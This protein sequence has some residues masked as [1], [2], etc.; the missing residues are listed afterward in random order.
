MSL[1]AMIH[2][3]SRPTEFYQR[4]SDHVQ[5][6]DI[7]V[8]SGGVSYCEHCGN[9]LSPVA[10]KCPNCGQPGP[11]VGYA[12]SFEPS[13]LDNVELADYWRR[14]GASLIDGVIASAFIVGITLPFA[15]TATK[16]DLGDGYGPVVA[17]LLLSTLG[18]GLYRTLMEGSR[19]GQ[20]LGKMVLKIAVRDERTV[21]PIG[22]GRAL[23]RW[24]VG[25][26]AWLLF[27]LP[28]V[29]DLLFPLWDQK[30][31]TLHDKAARSVVVSLRAQ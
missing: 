24:L 2:I 31:Q 23:I 12:R 8:T 20:T 5:D 28:G 26:G 27:Y 18:I 19:R 11:Q 16:G 15:L 25:A 14:V 3:L 10:A 1:V 30:N 29:I 9:E 17:I 7:H 13:A 21:A 6:A 22:Y 4:R